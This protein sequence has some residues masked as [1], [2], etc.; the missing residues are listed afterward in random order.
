MNPEDN[1]CP[2]HYP[3]IRN[4]MLDVSKKAYDKG[5]AVNFSDEETNGNPRVRLQVFNGATIASE[6]LFELEYTEGKETIL[7]GSYRKFYQ[8]EDGYI[9]LRDGSLEFI[10]GVLLNTACQESEVLR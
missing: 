6:R 4:I 2:Y 3:S 9:N 10:L 5:K 1:R 7:I 8:F